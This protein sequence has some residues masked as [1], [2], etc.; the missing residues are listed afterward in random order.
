MLSSMERTRV[1]RVTVPGYG[2]RYPLI[3]W[4][5]SANWKL[6]RKDRPTE[7]SSGLKCHSSGS[8]V[9]SMIDS[10]DSVSNI[11]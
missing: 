9:A 8:R 5:T 10:S 3:R 11:F 7:W 6:F 4:P 2:C 1:V